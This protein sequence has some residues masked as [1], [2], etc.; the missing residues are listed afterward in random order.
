MHVPLLRVYEHLPKHKEHARLCKGKQLYTS[1]MLLSVNA[2]WSI[3]THTCSAGLDH[4]HAQGIN[5]LPLRLVEALANCRRAAAA[6]QAQMRGKGCDTSMY[7]RLHRASRACPYGNM[8]Q[9]SE[10]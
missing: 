1:I 8:P 7:P 6:H 5:Q 3:Y 2:A 9:A 10:Q 4:R